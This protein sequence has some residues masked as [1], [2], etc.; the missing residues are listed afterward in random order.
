LIDIAAVSEEVARIN[1][2]RADDEL[3]YVV[4]DN[5][6][7]TPFCQRPLA[8]GADFVVHS[9]TKGIGGFGTDMGG[10]VIGPESFYDALLL[11]RKDFGGVL[12][13][14]AAWSIMV[15]GLPSLPIRMERMQRTA[16]RIAAF[17]VGHPAVGR[18]RYPGL[19][20]SS[21]YKLAAKQ[22]RDYSGRFAPGSMIYF[23]TAGES[24]E[25]QHECGARLIDHLARHAYTVCLAVSLG[26]IRTLVE[27]PSSMTH[28][29]VPLDE[30]ARMGIHPGGVR[31]SIGLEAEDDIL[32]DL[33]HA[34][35]AARVSVSEP[36]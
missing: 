8:F 1:E 4:V 25:E 21:D 34:L 18:V 35:E 32:A 28:A 30:Q 12:S 11:Y 31:L 5:T 15:H 2:S 27:H 23:E 26:N 3:V 33:K 36:V 9:L 14:R 10:V 22:M 6:F 16:Q 29:G 7:S 19:E 17:L 13:P 24:T 20:N